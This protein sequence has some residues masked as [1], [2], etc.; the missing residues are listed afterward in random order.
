MNPLTSVLPMAKGNGK[1]TDETAKAKALERVRETSRAVRESEGETEDR[2]DKRNDAIVEA[3][4]Y[5]PATEIADAAEIKQSY[6]SR[7]IRSKGKPG[8]GS[9]IERARD[10]ET[11]RA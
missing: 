1:T 4:K 10:G 8:S 11:A 9:A 7:V 5:A 6:I 2:R 3:A